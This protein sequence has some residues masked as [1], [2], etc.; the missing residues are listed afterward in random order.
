MRLAAPPKRR[1]RPGWPGWRV[2]F[3]QSWQLLSK[4]QL[5]MK[6]MDKKRVARRSAKPEAPL[7]PLSAA[8]PAAEAK[9]PAPRNKSGPARRRGENKGA[10]VQSFIKNRSKFKG[11]KIPFL[12]DF[13]K[14]S[15]YE[16]RS[17]KKPHAR[18]LR[19]VPLRSA[20]PFALAPSPASVRLVA[21]EALHARAQAQHFLQRV[22]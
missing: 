15:C 22:G 3:H 20:E 16:E 1:H 11:S 6:M 12:A 2:C 4:F 14:T 8:R 18:R 10:I 21:H 19:L 17:W 13:T 5:K 7:Q 9:A